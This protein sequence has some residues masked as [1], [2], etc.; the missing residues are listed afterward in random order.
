MALNW[1]EQKT[2]G[3]F[4]KTNGYFSQR[5]FGG[6]GCLFMLHRVQR[7]PERN[8]FPLNKGLSI[9]PEK[10]EEHIRFFIKEGFE[11]LSMDEVHAVA[12]G[13]KKP[14]KRFVAFTMDDGYE[15]NFT[16]GLPVFEKYNVP[17]IVYIT[18]GFTNKTAFPW[19][20]ILEH[21]L[22]SPGELSISINGNLKNYRWNSIDEGQRHYPELA[23]LFRKNDSPDTR[24][25]LRQLFDES[26]ITHIMD[27][28]LAPANWEALI[29]F[30]AHPLV[31]LG[32]HTCN[33]FRLS[34]LSFEDSKNE[35]FLSKKEL[36]ERLEQHIEHFAYPYGG[37][38][39]VSSREL[40][41]TEEA[42]YK[43]AVLNFP[44][45]VLSSNKNHFMCLPRYPLGEESTS[46]KLFENIR[47]ITHFGTNGF[48][49]VHHAFVR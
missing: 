5:V 4:V 22:Q 43:T 32:A 23:E 27:H 36:E 39:D 44:G 37:L 3:F 45:A 41:L 20:Y 34:G 7:T 42:G 1:L 11:F 31:T 26:E 8:L 28:V 25:S 16:L 38:E 13:N 18:T 17:F 47:G 19:W 21:T 46:A 35:I 33:H 40:M 49:S 2:L 14:K 15:D 10:L 9:T 48:Q 30:G 29:R 12:A 6:L 24:Q